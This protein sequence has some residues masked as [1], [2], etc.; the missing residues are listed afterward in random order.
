MELFSILLILLSALLH[1]LWNYLVKK[2]RDKQVFLW[3]RMFFILV[4]FLPVFI[5]LT[6]I[7][8]GE[9][10]WTILFISAAIHTVYNI[11]LAKTYEAGDISLTYPIVRAYPLFALVPAYFIFNETISTSAGAGMILIVC[12]LYSIN[13]RSI[14][15][16][17]LLNPITHYNRRA[18]ML[19]AITALICATYSI[20]DKLGVLSGSAFVF[21]YVMT[22]VQFVMYTVY[23]SRV[24]PIKSFKIEWRKN[25]WTAAFAGFLTFTAYIII[26][27]TFKTNKVA[28]VVALRQVSIV[29]GVLL[30]VVFLKEKY[31]GVRF[32]ASILIFSGAYLI[33][34]SN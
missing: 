20:S 31:G 32:I 25:K 9:I 33:G 10:Y 1:A 4:M 22:M 30:G 28:Y 2:S 19:A 3:L 8:E 23:L 26:L 18:V 13:L 6:W 7:G 27:I 17:G 14:T 5:Y 29:F 12:G 21:F 24:K 15:V 34:I 16:K 11:F